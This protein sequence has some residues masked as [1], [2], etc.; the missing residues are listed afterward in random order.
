MSPKFHVHKFTIQGLT[1]SHYSFAPLHRLAGVIP[2]GSPKAK[3]YFHPHE[4]DLYYNHGILP[5]YVKTL[6]KNG[7]DFSFSDEESTL[8]LREV[9]IGV[10]VLSTNIYERLSLGLDG[11]LYYNSN[12]DIV[13]DLL[14]PSLLGDFKKFFFKDGSSAI[15]WNDSTGHVAYAYNPYGAVW[16]GFDNKWLEEEGHDKKEM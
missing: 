15:A 16:D 1:P 5:P 7:I 9:R 14:N 8:L 11:Y 10:S 6:E 12:E 3:L 2:I 13:S 4:K